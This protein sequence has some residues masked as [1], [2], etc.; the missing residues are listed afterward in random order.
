[1]KKSRIINIINNDNNYSIEIATL[2]K[3]Q[4]IQYDYLVSEKYNPDAELN[5][6]IGGDGS[7]LRSL[8]LNDFPDIPIIGI[9]TGNLGFYPELSPKDIENFAVD[10]SNGN[11]SVNKL[12]LIQC[13]ICSEEVISTVFALNDIA[14]KGDQTKTIHLDVFIDYNHLQTIS[15]DG[16]IIS[17]PMGSSAYNYSA[18][19]SLVYPALSTLQVTPIAPLNSNAYRC[20]ASSVIVPPDLHIIIVPEYKYIEKVVFSLDGEQMN[21]EKVTHANFFVSKKFINMVSMGT[22][23]YWKV[24]KEKF[25]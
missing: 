15:G 3:R 25:L 24:I 14:I 22:F 23:N 2:I 8:R 16:V 21:F 20:L 11:Y 19:G 9:N 7:F 17:T 10:Y 13:E 1:M 12:Q 4:L 5:I 6:S 18:G